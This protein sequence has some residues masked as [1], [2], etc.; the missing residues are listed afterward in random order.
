[1]HDLFEGVVPYELKLLIL[2]CVRMKYFTIDVLNERINAYDFVSDRPTLIDA[3][4]VSTSAMKI[5]QSA[6]QM[7]HL[8]RELPMLV[9]DLIP[10]DDENWY[11][12]LVLLKICTIPV[13]TYDTISFLRVLIEEKLELF[14]KLY[15]VNSMIPYMVHSSWSVDTILEYES[16]LSFIKRVS[17]RSNYKNV[18]LT[19]AKKHQFWLCHQMVSSQLLT[20]TLDQSNKQLS[21][22]LSEEEDYLQEE[23][24][25][26]MHSRC[27]CQPSSLGYFT[28]LTVT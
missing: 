1:M 25:R 10:P 28:K 8:S 14:K 3:R 12:F 13:C 27:S 9:A 4:I 20:P 19:V 17:H 23:C 22:V 24:L 6:S 11:S 15:P 21:C 16:K 7:M 18:C 26:I 2:H 5:R